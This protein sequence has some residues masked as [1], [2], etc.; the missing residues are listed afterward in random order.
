MQGQH[1]LPLAM[2]VNRLLGVVLRNLDMQGHGRPEVDIGVIAAQQARERR[3]ICHDLAIICLFFYI[4]PR[5]GF[6][7]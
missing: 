6:V 5:P 2:A 1:Q 7:Q 3:A 4:Q